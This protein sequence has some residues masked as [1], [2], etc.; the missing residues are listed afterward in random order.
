MPIPLKRSFSGLTLALTILSQNIEGFSTNKG[1]LL[2]I[3]CD[4]NDCDI[5]CGQETH[6]DRASSR[7]KIPGMILIKEIPS[8]T[9][10]SAVFSKPLLI[11]ESAEH[12]NKGNIEIITI[13][14]KGIRSLQYTIHQ[15]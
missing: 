12:C 5:L 9:Y 13:E 7:P 4:E 2:A 6:R 10:G 11:I 1:E 8:D 3:L 14:V 15:I